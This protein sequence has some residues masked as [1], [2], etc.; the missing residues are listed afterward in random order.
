MTLLIGDNIQNGEYRRLIGAVAAGTFAW[1]EN[2][3]RKSTY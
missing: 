1:G 3:C 2:P